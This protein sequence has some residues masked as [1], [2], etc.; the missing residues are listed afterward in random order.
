M[1][2][3]CKR[4]DKP[5]AFP[6]GKFCGAACSA[7]WE[8]GDRNG[9]QESQ[10]DVGAFFRRTTRRAILMRMDDAKAVVSAGVATWEEAFKDVER[11][12]GGSMGDDAVSGD[13]RSAR[14]HWV[15]GF[16][17]PGARTGPAI[18]GALREFNS[19]RG[20]PRVQRRLVSCPDCLTKM[21]EPKGL[22][23]KLEVADCSDC[24]F[25]RSNSEYP[26]TLCA[27]SGQRRVGGMSHYESG[28]SPDWCPLRSASVSVLLKG[29]V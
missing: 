13:S 24:P 18:C 21:G 12:I 4:C 7:R 25:L 11:W 15:E 16:D 14:S 29:K 10:R 8:R 22:S 26:E 20:W 17:S 6:G 3:T 5:V 1:R 19:E 27:A 28:P 9:R 2:T 23:L